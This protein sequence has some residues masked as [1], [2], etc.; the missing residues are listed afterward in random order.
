MIE[1]RHIKSQNSLKGCKKKRIKRFFL[2]Q[3]L[4]CKILACSSNYWLFVW[5]NIWERNDNALIS[6]SLWC[7]QLRND[8]KISYQFQLFSTINYRF[9][10]TG[11]ILLVWWSLFTCIEL[12]H[13]VMV[14][15][16]SSG[17]A[18]K[19]IWVSLYHPNGFSISS[20]PS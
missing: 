15:L 11:F 19:F 4:D 2:R 14:W 5:V 6:S 8:F 18:K 17:L 12:Q 20:S 1:S 3:R 9:V 7:L 16:G 10:T 13:P